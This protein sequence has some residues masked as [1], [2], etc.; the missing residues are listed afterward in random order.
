MLCRLKSGSSQAGCD[1][2]AAVSGIHRHQHVAWASHA[3]MQPVLGPYCEFSALG[4]NSLL[5]LSAAIPQYMTP[6]SQSAQCLTIREG[7][8]SQLRTLLA[9]SLHASLHPRCLS[10]SPDMQRLLKQF[11][12]DFSD[13]FET[14]AVDRGWWESRFRS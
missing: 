10:H 6:P 8:A 5:Q 9:M 3:S 4:R 13:A 2:S 12:V 14:G 11:C 7:F 1:N